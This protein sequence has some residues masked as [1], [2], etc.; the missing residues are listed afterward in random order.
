MNMKLKEQ[1]AMRNIKNNF[2]QDP[3]KNITLMSNPILS[4]VRTELI[5][6]PHHHS[7]NDTWKKRKCL[8]Q[9][10]FQK[11]LSTLALSWVIPRS[12]HF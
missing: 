9:I 12:E 10:Y 4:F 7:N 1:V 3:T 6:I 2:I 5:A 11:Q 8:T